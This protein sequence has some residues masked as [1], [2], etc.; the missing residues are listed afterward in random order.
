MIDPRERRREY[1]KAYRKA[2]REK[3]RA[4]S[5]A[6]YA[7]N[8]EKMRAARDEWRA[9]NKERDR[10]TSKAWHDANKEKTRKAGREWAE[11][12]KERKKETARRWYIANAE[13]QRR[14]SREWAAANPDKVKKNAAK[15][16]AEDHKA[17]RHRRKARKLNAVGKWS[18]ADLRIVKSILG[19]MCLKCGSAE[20]ISVDHVIPLAMGGSNQPTNLQPLCTSCNSRKGSRS[21]ADYRTKK[22]IAKIMDAFQ[23]KT[24]LR[25]AY[26]CT[27]KDLGAS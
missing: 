19:D 20:R 2:N 13:D 8:K 7:A 10:A 24:P 3:E 12:N 27:L 15:K 4:R 11:K 23:I 21:M 9:K 6:I 5:A 14:R 22:Q 1:K 25:S 17:A 26:G 16:T 18:A